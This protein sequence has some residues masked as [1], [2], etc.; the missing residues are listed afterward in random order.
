MESMQRS[1]A[2]AEVSRSKLSHSN[3]RRP[4]SG[5]LVSSAG[6]RKANTHNALRLGRRGQ[7]GGGRVVFN[8]TGG[9]GS[10]NGEAATIE[11]V[12]EDGDD[13]AGAVHGGRGS[14]QAELQALR[15]GPAIKNFGGEDEGLE[16]SGGERARPG[17]AVGD[18][19]AAFVRGGAAKFVERKNV[20]GPVG[21]HVG[22]HK[23]FGVG[24][25]EPGRGSEEPLLESEL[26]LFT[27]VFCG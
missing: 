7:S 5:I 14:G 4:T 19:S 22:K 16:V 20:V 10:T 25:V 17:F 18:E 3:C 15:V 12:A 13:L 26:A 2:T 8:G 1:A 23:L 27:V 24:G 21:G 9:F 6:T 11:R